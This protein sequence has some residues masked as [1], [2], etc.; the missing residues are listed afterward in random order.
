MVGASPILLAMTIAAGA[1]C[2]AP[3]SGVF[4][5]SR[6]TLDAGRVDAPTSSCRAIGEPRSPATPMPAALGPTP[7]AC[8]APQGSA[9][10]AETLASADDAFA[11]AFYVP[12]AT[13]AATPNVILSPYSVSATLT[14][15]GAGAEGETATQ[16]ESVLML[17][18]AAASVAPAYTAL[19]CEDET[20]GTY[21]GDQLLIAN[22]VW[23]QQGKAFVPTFLSLLAN[24]FA[25]PLHAVDFAGDPAGAA[26]AI[27]AW[28]SEHTDGQIPEL[29][30]PSDIDD[31]TAIVLVDALYFKGTWENGF[32][33]METSSLPFTLADGTQVSVPTMAGNVW[34]STGSLGASGLGALDVYELPYAGGKV[35]MDFLVPSGGSLSAVEAALTPTLL[36]QAIASLTTHEQDN[37][38]V[39][40]F[41]ITTH[42]EL[43]PVLVGMGMT[44]AFD[45]G[46][47]NLSGIDGELDLYVS[48][49]VHQATI[50][51]DESGTL[52]TAAT[53]AVGGCLILEPPSPVH[54]DSPF[55]FLIRDTKN[56]SILFMGQVED[57][58][59]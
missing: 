12:A 59:Q 26:S 22:S 42:L 46:T 38:Y 53:G 45:A 1:A 14:M 57:P 6:P 19:A 51:V 27:D 13:A 15:V 54:I 49:V 2:G 11:V 32:D 4:S 28:V 41:S 5:E 36:D 7:D 9:A 43:A 48:A 21:V 16:I 55:L 35:A 24:G 52:A 10:A 23:G 3:S 37:L 29:L 50:E 31:M 40:K 44:D 25:A 17:P 33:P 58:R 56:G 30:G 34:L 18:A 8:G 39:P 20:D 47:A